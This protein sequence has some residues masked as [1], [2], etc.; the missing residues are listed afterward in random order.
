[1]VLCRCPL[2]VK[3]RHSAV[4]SS[5]PV[6]PRKQTITHCR[7]CEIIAILRITPAILA[8]PGFVKQIVCQGGL[9]LSF[10]P[11][12]RTRNLGRRSRSVRC[13]RAAP[14]LSTCL[15]SILFLSP[16]P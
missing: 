3:S 7:E 13:S 5:C 6:F 9:N 4:Q 2:W 14:S 1:M 10:E 11:H 8:D 16:N 12:R 15:H